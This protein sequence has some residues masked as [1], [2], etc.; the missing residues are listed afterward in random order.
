MYKINAIMLVAILQALVAQSNA[1]VLM[2]V[3]R[4]LSSSLIGTDC[5]NLP[6]KM[7]IYCCDLS[8]TSYVVCNLNTNEIVSSDCPS[9][10]ICEDTASGQASCP[11]A[12]GSQSCK[13]ASVGATNRVEIV[14]LGTVDEQEASPENT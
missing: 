8:P 13:R 1:R 7:G 10:D 12:Q 9:G 14:T 4:T 6:D 2:P 11:A 5:S 3:K